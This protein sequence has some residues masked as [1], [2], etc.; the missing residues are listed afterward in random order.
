[1]LIRPACVNDIEAVLA[2]WSDAET[3]PTHTDNA[4]GL[5]VLLEHDPAC[6]IVAEGDGGLV[7]TVIAAWDGWRGSI[8]RLAVH[9][10]ARREGLARRLLSEAENRLAELGAKRLQA[11][12]VASDDRATGF[13]RASG[14]QEQAG[15]LRFVKG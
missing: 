8:Y 12:V 10:H 1:M 9:P 3:E 5:R 4:A 13:W 14:W 6:L 7:G 15:R 11:V 2:L